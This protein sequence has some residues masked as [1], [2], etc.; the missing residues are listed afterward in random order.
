MTKTLQKQKEMAKWKA[1]CFF[2]L[3]LQ[4]TSRNIIHVILYI[5]TVII[6]VIQEKIY[7]KYVGKHIVMQ[8]IRIDEI[9]SVQK[10]TRT[11]PAY[12]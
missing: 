1:K 8:F 11:L 12:S 9:L 2:K 4:Q 10:E 7:K 6:V 5:Q 3:D